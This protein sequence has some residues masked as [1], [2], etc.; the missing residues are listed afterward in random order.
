[1]GKPHSWPLAA[2]VLWV[3]E[4]KRCKHEGRSGVASPSTKLHAQAP[5]P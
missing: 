2:T 4:S 3:A 1:M 5:A